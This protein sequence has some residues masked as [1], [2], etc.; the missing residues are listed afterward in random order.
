MRFELARRI[1]VLVEIGPVGE[2]VAEQAMH[3]RAGERGVGAGLHQHRQVGLLHR[4]VHVDVDGRDLRA[5]LLAG[6]ARVG[7]HVDLRVHRVGAPDHDQVRLRHLARIDAGDLAAAGREARI[8][9]V[10]ADRR[11]IAGILLHVAQAVHAVAHHEA[12]RAGV[13]VRPHALGAVAPLGR[14]ELLGDEIERVVPRDALEAAGPL[15]ADAAQR[16]QETVG[17]IGALGVA[18]D[19]GADDAARVVVVLRAAHPADPAVDDV[20]LERAGGRAVV[21]TGRIADP[22][23]LG[24]PDGLIHRPGL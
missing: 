5:A 16:M 14:V 18:R 7:H 10:D 15:R 12:H 8:G 13:I 9:R 20:D 17:M 11:V 1:G 4:A 19:L 6:A 24:E 23:A 2:A 21:R 22:P 3:H